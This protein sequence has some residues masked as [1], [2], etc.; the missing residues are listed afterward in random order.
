[1]RRASL[2]PSLQIGALHEQDMQ[3][4]AAQCKYGDIHSQRGAWLFVAVH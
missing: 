1:L 3:M 2:P 4:P